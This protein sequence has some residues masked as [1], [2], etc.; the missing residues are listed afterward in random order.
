[1]LEEVWFL[2]TREN[3]IGELTLAN[4]QEPVFVECL[5]C[6]G[7]SCDTFNSYSLLQQP[8]EASTILCPCHR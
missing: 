6:A 1:M 4:N 7:D 8:L 2:Q 3:K 5:L